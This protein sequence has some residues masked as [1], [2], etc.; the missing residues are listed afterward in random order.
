MSAVLTNKTAL[1]TGGSRGIGYAIAQALANA[2]ATV[3]ISSRS[4]D[5]LAEAAKS[6][7]TES[8]TVVPIPSDVSDAASIE[9]LIS[10]VFEK[11]GSIDILVNNAG[12]TRDNLM[13][14]LKEDDWDAVLDINLKGA[15]LCTKF[16]S[17]QM[18]RQKSGSIINI[19][20]VVGMTGNPGQTNYASSK[21]GLLGLTK[22]TALELASRGIRVNAIAPGYIDTEMT[23]RLNENQRNEL[24]ERIPLGRIGTP[25]DVAETAL[26][27]ASPAAR[28]I[29]GQVIRVDGGMV[30]S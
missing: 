29:T 20:S 16:A 17:R 28:Y 13:L 19:S 30:M 23:D 21:A 9:S 8:N 5:V 27:L 4:E 24:T 10:E 12:I 11:F 25:E 7:S 26:F 15:F 1:V 18:L 22:S 6:L 3:T 14:R 2:G